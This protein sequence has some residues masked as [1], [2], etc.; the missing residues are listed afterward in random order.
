MEKIKPEIFDLK[1]LK[2]CKMYH[3]GEKRMMK[4]EVEEEIKKEVEKKDEE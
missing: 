4:C 2:N 3:E 1:R